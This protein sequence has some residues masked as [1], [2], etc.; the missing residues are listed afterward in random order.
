MKRVIFISAALAAAM[1]ITVSASAAN[2]PMKRLGN[3][4]E[5]ASSYGVNTACLQSD[6][7]VKN[8]LVVKQ[9]EAFVVPAGK[10]LVLKNGCKIKGTL[11]IENGGSVTVKSG[12][13]WVSGSVINNGTLSV[14][15]KA[16]LDVKNN[17]LLYTAYDGTFKSST[18]DI[19]IAD[20]A[21][22]FCLGKNVVKNCSCD[23]LIRLVP[24]IDSI[25]IVTTDIGGKVLT[26]EDIDFNAA[27]DMLKADY[28]C[29][30]EVPIGGASV[31]LVLDS[32]IDAHENA[33]HV[34]V[35]FVSGRIAQIGSAPMRYI[36]N[37]AGLRDDETVYSEGLA[38]KW[39]KKWDS[40]NSNNAMVTSKISLYT[41]QMGDDWLAVMVYPTYK[42]YAAVCYRL[43][44]GKITELGSVAPCGLDF[45]VLK[46]GS[47][48][49]LHTTAEVPFTSGPNAETSTDVIDSFYKV[50]KKSIKLLGSFEHD[51]LNNWAVLEGDEYIKVAEA[52]YTERMTSLTAG[53]SS[54]SK[55]AVE[56]PALEFEKSY[57]NFM[58]YIAEHLSAAR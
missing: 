8:T 45:E 31:S 11:Y 13:L 19:D 9:N 50:G 5:Y 32:E 26:S 29:A 6:R 33:S 38:R 23:A 14:G 18:I 46:K 10:K 1:M 57:G 52:E 22:L 53:Y 36:L 37:T 15:V 58:K 4:A 42:S 20:K 17:G 49:I 28:S 55:T 51:D 35:S 2:I 25:K 30:D 7:T 40:I 27:R 34:E 54:D 47:G 48:Y 39:N 43:S 24:L 12:T 41:Y 16:K 56:A 44:G 3:S 21:N